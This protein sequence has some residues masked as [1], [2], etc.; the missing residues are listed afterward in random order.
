MPDI[1][2]EH[3]SIAANSRPTKEIDYSDRIYLQ[4]STKYDKVLSRRK[5]D[6]LVKISLHHTHPNLEAHL[7]TI[8]KSDQAPSDRLVAATA[9]LSAL[10]S[11]LHLLSPLSSLHDPINK[12]QCRFIRILLEYCLYESNCSKDLHQVL[13]RICGQLWLLSSSDKSDHNTPIISLYLQYVCH[14]LQ[15]SRHS[16]SDQFIQAA[17]GHVNNLLQRPGGVDF[18]F[19]KDFNAQLAASQ[20]S[21]VTELAIKILEQVALPIQVTEVSELLA[22]LSSIYKQSDAENFRKEFASQFSKISDILIGWCVSPSSLSNRMDLGRIYAIF[23]KEFRFWWHLPEMNMNSLLSDLLSDW[24]TTL[25]EAVRIEKEQTCTTFSRHKSKDKDSRKP[26]ATL[27]DTILK[28]QLY[29]NVLIAILTGVKCHWENVSQ[30]QRFDLDFSSTLNELSKIVPVLVGLSKPIVNNDRNILPVSRVPCTILGNAM[31][32]SCTL[33]SLLLDLFEHNF[34]PRNC[35]KIVMLPHE[36]IQRDALTNPEAIQSVVNLLKTLEGFTEFADQVRDL[37]VLLLDSKLKLSDPGISVVES[38]RVLSQLLEVTP[39]SY[40]WKN[41]SSFL[42]DEHRTLLLLNILSTHVDSRQNM[43]KCAE[44]IDNLVLSDQ[45]MQLSLRVR[46]GLLSFLREASLELTGNIVCQLTSVCGISTDVLY[47]L[48]FALASI[49]ASASHFPAKSIL[50]L[51]R[52]MELILDHKLSTLS[53]KFA[54]TTLNLISTSLLNIGARDFLVQYKNCLEPLGNMC[55]TL[56]SSTDN[57]ILG[58]AASILTE[59]YGYFGAKRLVKSQ[60][61]TKVILAWHCFH[62][63]DRCTPLVG[64]GFDTA[65]QHSSGAFPSHNI[66]SDFMV[67]LSTGKLEDCDASEW[68]ERTAKLVSPVPTESLEQVDAMEIVLSFLC[69]SLVESKLK[70]PPWN[71]SLRTLQAIEGAI[72]GLLHPPPANMTSE[73]VEKNPLAGFHLKSQESFALLSKEQ[74]LTHVYLLLRFIDTLQRHMENGINGFALMYPTPSPSALAFYEANKATCIEWRKRMC[75][76][77]IKLAVNL[78]VFA[79]FDKDLP[80]EV[81]A[82]IVNQSRGL[83]QEILASDQPVE[84]LKK[85]A[86]LEEFFIILAMAYYHLGSNAELIA[87][88]L[89]LSEL[90]PEAMPGNLVWVKTLAA[91][92]RGH[93]DKALELTRQ[94]TS[95][96]TDSKFPKF[97]QFNLAIEF[98]LNTIVEGKLDHNL[99]KEASRQFEWKRLECLDSLSDWGSL[100][101]STCACNNGKKFDLKQRTA[102]SWQSPQVLSKLESFLHQSFCNSQESIDCI[103]NEIIEHESVLNRLQSLVSMADQSV[104]EEIPKLPFILFEHRPLLA[105]KLSLQ[106]DYSYDVWWPRFLNMKGPFLKSLPGFL[107]SSLDIKSNVQFMRSIF[108][109]IGIISTNPD[110]INQF[111]TATNSFVG[112]DIDSLDLLEL[113]SLTSQV[114]LL[115]SCSKEQ[116]I[117]ALDLLTH[118][119]I[120]TIQDES[121]SLDFREKRSRLVASKLQTL[122]DFLQQDSW[123]ETFHQSENSASSSLASRLLYIS[124]L[125]HVPWLSRLPLA[126]P[127]KLCDV[128]SEKWLKTNPNASLSSLLVVATKLSSHSGDAW[129]RMANWCYSHGLSSI[130][131]QKT[132]PKRDHLERYST[133][134]G[135]LFAK[136][137]NKEKLWQDVLMVVQELVTSSV[138]VPCIDNLNDEISLKMLSS[139]LL[140]K[141]SVSTDSATAQLEAAHHLSLVWQEIRPCLKELFTGHELRLLEKSAEAFRTYL[142]SFYVSVERNS[143]LSSS[144]IDYANLPL[145]RKSACLKMLNLL[146]FPNYKLRRRMSQLFNPH[147]SLDFTSC[148]AWLDCQPDLLV[149]LNHQDP[150]VRETISQLICEHLLPSLQ[151]YYLS[152]HAST[153]NYLSAIVLPA[154]VNLISM[155][156]GLTDAMLSVDVKPYYERIISKIESICEDDDATPCKLKNRKSVAEVSMA[157]LVQNT[158]LFVRELIRIALL[159]DELWIGFLTHYSSMLHKKCEMVFKLYQDLIKKNSPVNIIGPLNMNNPLKVIKP[160]SNKENHVPIVTALSGTKETRKK[161]ATT[162]QLTTLSTELDLCVLEDEQKEYFKL[163]MKEMVVE[164]TVRLFAI[165]KTATV[166]RETETTHESWFKKCATPLIGACLTEFKKF[167]HSKISLNTPV[168]LIRNLVRALQ[169][170]PPPAKDLNAELDTHSLPLDEQQQDHLAASKMRSAFINIKSITSASWQQNCS[171]CVLLPGM[172]GKLVRAVGQS[173]SVLNTKT[174]P[175]MFSLRSSE[176]RVYPYLLKGLED[177]RLDERVMHQLKLFNLCVTTSQPTLMARTYEVTPLGT[178]IGLIQMVQ[179]ATPLFVLYKRH[180]LRQLERMKI[181][182][183]QKNS[184]AV[185]MCDEEQAIHKSLR[186][187]EL[188]YERLKKHA[189]SLEVSKIARNEWPEDSL[190]SVFESL[191]ED[192]PA[193]LLSQELWGCSPSNAQWWSVT[194]RYIHSLASTSAFCH[195]FGL[196]DRHLDNLMVDLVNGQMVHID[197]NICFERGT[198]MRVPEKVPFR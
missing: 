153:M 14:L 152:H 89:F 179:G 95:G 181:L 20:L 32:N 124:S 94:T 107:T 33:I 197:F 164:P 47:L 91:V 190:R 67:I 69:T 194:R 42:K 66:L 68:F 93:L 110:L 128:K 87:L 64:T 50:A 122:F 46:I 167:D 36:L 65:T 178:H 134:L 116:Q 172:G 144:R 41:V 108:S 54:L 88:H 6:I 111:T 182:V 148:S 192:T 184:K 166:D 85:Y 149:R 117:S 77:V 63:S 120:Q 23:A 125:E 55:Q 11:D 8:R 79:D 188:F 78:P 75:R 1:P 22:T 90:L 102:Q 121:G 39:P 16:N 126:P 109:N 10:G 81:F 183:N 72:R 28:S 35:A 80:C 187:S 127:F 26:T 189:S 74:Q 151:S 105:Y 56:L 82:F 135:R 163:A 193:S 171:H 143:R 31:C 92:C 123:I 71:N 101:K 130:L 58:L 3:N 24:I 104:L 118:T 114:A 156:P 61:S 165:L 37:W 83:L 180:Q 131:S 175:K 113:G 60:L 133:R 44:I 84:H 173:I 150:L 29:A 9:L 73:V 62:R 4:I 132:C 2:K 136:K 115:A 191:E 45:W 147:T 174:R 96:G 49:K 198:L 160:G 129:L 177:L 30:D 139:K 5:Q 161:S 196:G 43:V 53:Q 186:P 137:V 76:L 140:E 48:D 99:L 18:N 103:R 25:R 19:R 185:D 154:I 106:N 40:A 100:T 159:W 119:I 169:E 17:L 15:M 12:E 21:K 52:E 34:E 170:L 168:Q 138:N 57:R 157:Q 59:L 70:S 86:D 162:N 142:T 13:S 141:H 27:T 155:R 158:R 176:G 112:S 97:D 7:K 51:L 146:T 195:V 145:N 38:S 98:H